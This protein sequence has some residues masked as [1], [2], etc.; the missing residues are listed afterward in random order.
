MNRL[1]DADNCNLVGWVL[2]VVFLRLRA[3]EESKNWI[4]AFAGKLDNAD[5]HSV[6]NFPTIHYRFPAKAGIQFFSFQRKGSKPLPPSTS[7]P[8]PS[9]KHPAGILRYQGPFYFQHKPD[10]AMAAAG[11]QQTERL[12][13]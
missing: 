2:W 10:P 3:I 12:A 4:P 11:W 9:Y 1:L 5:N 7:N 13:Y 8:P 6:I